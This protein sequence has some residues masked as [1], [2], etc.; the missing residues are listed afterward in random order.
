MDFEEARILA[1]AWWASNIVGLIFVLVAIK[2][3]RLARFMFVL[4]FGYASWVNYTLSHENPDVYLDYA[5]HAI[6]VYTRF[7]LGWFSHHITALVTIIAA[8]QLCIA[9]GMLLNR[10]FVT[11]ACIGVIVF[12]VAIAPLGL[13]AAF[14]FSLTVSF[15]AF[16]IIKRDRKE[17][18]WKGRH[19]GTNLAGGHLVR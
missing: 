4:L 19:V 3:T 8:G 17:Y 16:L 10:S 15:A 9:V 5:D 12:L 2:S 13:Y 14:P 1:F 18:L 6:G 11:L 7:I